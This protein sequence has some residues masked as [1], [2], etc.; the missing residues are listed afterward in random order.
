MVDSSDNVREFFRNEILEA[1]PAIRK[2]NKRP[3]SKA[4]FSYIARNSATNVDESFIDK[5]LN[6]LFAEKIIV[7]SP[8]SCGDSFFVVENCLAEKEK[9]LQKS[10]TIKSIDIITPQKPK[11]NSTDESKGN[12]EQKQNEHRDRAL[13]SY[14]SLMAKITKLKS[15]VIEELYTVNKDFTYLSSRID[16]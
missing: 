9:D 5:M 13:N 12:T 16:S 1:I 10:F 7:N 2:K 14:E 3:D 8:K 15:F 11:I 4:I 6:E